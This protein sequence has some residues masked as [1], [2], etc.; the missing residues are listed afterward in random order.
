M[1]TVAVIFGGR[2][3]EHDISIITGQFIIEALKAARNFEIIPVYIGKDGRWYSHPKLARLATFQNDDFEEMLAKLRSTG[4]RADGRFEVRP[5]GLFSRWQTVDVVFP[6]LH[7]TYGEDGSLAGLLRLANVPFVGC[8]LAASAV[9]MDKVFCKM[10]TEAAGVPSVPYV[11]FTAEEYARN[12]GSVERKIE[13]KLAK[14]W[15]VKPAHLGSSIAV[16]KVSDNKYKLKDAIEVALHYDDKVIVEEGIEDLTEVNCAVLGNGAKLTLSELE[17]P[18]H[19]AEFLSFEDKYIGDGAKKSGGS[20]SGGKGAIK[21]PAPIPKQQADRVRELAERAFTAIGASG[22][23]RLDFMVDNA[24]RKV[25]LNEINPL[26]GNLQ[27][28]LWKASGVSNAELVTILIEL[29]EER[30]QHQQKL[31]TTFKSSVLS[32]PGGQKN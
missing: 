14:P 32:Q 21:I 10:A 2:S 28:H 5:A 11:W 23:A 8:D 31:V 3:A 29:A 17:Q 19:K 27:E 7:G 4:V 13:K 15:F 26:P 9:A 30:H 24:A 22:T 25:Y 1:K 18:L 12:A 6:A 20:M 16:T